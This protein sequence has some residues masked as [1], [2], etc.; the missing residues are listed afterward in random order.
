M[1]LQIARTINITLAAT[2][3]TLIQIKEPH[4]KK[5]KY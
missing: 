4:L 5:K 3:F 2:S 1:S